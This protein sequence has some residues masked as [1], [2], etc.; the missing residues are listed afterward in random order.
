MGS[1][2]GA[3]DGWKVLLLVEKSKEMCF[4]RLLEAGGAKVLAVR[5]PFTNHLD[6][7]HAFFDLHKVKV[8]AEAVRMKICI[9]T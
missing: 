1:I 7:S 2:I 6:A 3:F 9:A 5:P 8:T 4:K